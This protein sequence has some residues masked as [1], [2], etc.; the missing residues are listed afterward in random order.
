MATFRPA[1]RCGT[2]GA[3][4]AERGPR[5]PQVLRHRPGC[6]VPVLDAVE[7]ARDEVG[8]ALLRADELPDEVVAGLRLAATRLATAVARLEAR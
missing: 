5:S 8:C 4:S 7:E 2:C 1:A 6:S 3:E